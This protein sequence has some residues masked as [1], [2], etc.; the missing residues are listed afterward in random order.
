MHEPAEEVAVFWG[1]AYH[2]G[3]EANGDVLGVVEA[4]VDDVGVA[5]GIEE[6][7]TKLLRES[8]QILHGLGRERRQ[9]QAAGDGVERWIR[10]DGRCHTDRSRRRIYTWASR[11]DDHAS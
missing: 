4:G 3:D 11:S 1:E 2:L 8:F 5:H 10:R 9:Q 7:S 6:G